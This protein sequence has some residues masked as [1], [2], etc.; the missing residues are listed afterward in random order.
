[1]T[2]SLG[3]SCTMM[4]HL[5]FLRFSLNSCHLIGWLWPRDWIKTPIAGE[6]IGAISLLIFIF[7]PPP[8]LI[9]APRI[10]ALILYI[11][12]GWTILCTVACQK[13]SVFLDKLQSSIFNLW[14]WLAKQHLLTLLSLCCTD[15]VFELKP[16]RCS[17]RYN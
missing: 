11:I 15:W 13:H 7:A 4:T 12:D 5:P 17:W 2:R 6:H 1:M 8:P 9:C 3:D 10:L 16:F 14:N